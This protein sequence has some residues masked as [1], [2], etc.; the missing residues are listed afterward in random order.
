MNRRLIVALAG[1]SDR[2]YRYRGRSRSPS[3]IDRYQPDGHY[4]SFSRDREPRRRPP[5]PGPANIDRYVPSQDFKPPPPPPPP[6]VNPVPDPNKLDYQ[7]GF[8]YF[9]EWWRH[10]QII[11]EERERQRNG[12][13][14]PLDRAKADRE[15]RE[16]RA[17]EKAQI[18]AAYDTYKE[19]M[20]VKMAKA[21]VQ[22]HR[23]EEWFKERYVPAIRDDIRTRLTEVRR[24]HYGLWEREFDAGAFDGFSLEGIYKGDSNA[25]G[26]PVEKEEGET[27]ATAEVLGIGDLLPSKRGMVRDEAAHQPA[28]LIKTIAPS[29]SRA[30]LED[31]CREHL[32]ESAGGLK[33]LGLSDPN[34]SKRYHRIGWV[35]LHPGAEPVDRMDRGDG[36]GQESDEDGE[37]R[38]RRVEGTGADP[39][40]VARRALEAV[41]GKTIRDEVKGDF[42]VHVGVQAPLSDPKQ[43]ALWDLFSVPERIERDLQLASRLVFKLDSDAGPDFNGIAKVDER[44]DRLRANGQ[45]RSTTTTTAAAAAAAATLAEASPGS[46]PDGAR[47]AAET[48]DAADAGRAEAVDDEKEEGAFDEEG[49]DDDEE[50]DDDELLATKKKLDLLVEYLRRVH[51]F[52]FFCVFESDSVHELLRK[53]PGGH[54]R[55]PR[56]TLSS[57]A[58]AAA[59]A[60]VTGQPYLVKTDGKEDG[61]PAA[62]FKSRLPRH[63]S[64]NEQQLSRALNWVKTYE[65]KILQILEPENVD[66][67]KL[68]GK[69]LEDGLDEELSKYVRQEDESKFRCKVSNCTKLFKA[70]HFWRKHAEKRHAE[71]YESIKKDVRF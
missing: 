20:Q 70:E 50:K 30:K 63:A 4:G 2:R 7:V 41:D 3:T 32:G 45:L 8:S 36:R 34:P 64:K 54:L 62:S 38:V 24:G 49:E 65:E 51:N 11:K 28:L 17:K 27:V 56:A 35:M 23:A 12:G 25:Q 22:S 1:P 15:S 14:R 31:F 16:E 5:S 29:V 13:R 21:F 19:A 33:W 10:D 67:R 26:G 46:R 47:G 53:C 61:D 18:Q 43:K 69:P 37:D 39:D 6:A 55:R 57:P 44:V 42:T 60:S 9:G 40:S 59:V 58:K 71:W 68:G 52:C 48:D 66:L